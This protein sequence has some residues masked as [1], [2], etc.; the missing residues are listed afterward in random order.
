MLNLTMKTA[1]GTQRLQARD[2]I[3][4]SEVYGEARDA[5]GEGASTW[6]EATLTDATTGAFVA[7]L[8]Y[9]GK[10]WDT[11]RYTAGD[12]PVFDPYAPVRT[13]D[14]FARQFTTAGGSGVVRVYAGTGTAADP[15]GAAFDFVG[16][17]FM[18]VRCGARVTDDTLAAIRAVAAGAA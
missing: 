8:S 14:T 6:G 7:R 1:D 12:H 4:A 5:S 17:D 11:P 16:D 18:L 13:F 10:A 3:H 9:N 15:H 2:V